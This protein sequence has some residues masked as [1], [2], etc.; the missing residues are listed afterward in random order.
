MPAKLIDRTPSAYGYPLL[1]KHL[2]HAPLAHSPDQEIVYRDWCATPT[3]TSRSASAGWPTAWPSLGVKPGRHRRRHGLGQPP[4]P[5]VLLRRAHDGRDPAHVN[6]RLSPEQILYTH[7]PRGGRRPPRATRSSCRCSSR[8]RDRLDTVKQFVLLSDAAEPPRDGRAARRRVRGSCWPQSSAAY[9]FP[10]LD[11]NTRAP[12]PSTRP[13][14][15]GCPR[16]CT[17]A[18]GSSCC[19]R[20]PGSRR[21]AMS[22]QQGGFH[23][24]DVYMPITPMFHVHAWGYPVH[25]DPHGREAGLPG[26]LRPG[27]APAA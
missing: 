9:D 24:D 5:G 22:P 23:R 10:E 25:G 3:A 19:T 15:P 7:Q 18:T 2:L 16:A 4:L 21:M 20:W 13:G 12:R 8:S 27:R 26:P 17:T 11:E 6:V 1:I 14:R